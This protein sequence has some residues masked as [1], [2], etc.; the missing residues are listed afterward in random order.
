MTHTPQFVHFA[1]M[2]LALVTCAAGAA[3]PAGDDLPRADSSRLEE[4]IRALG[5]FG[6]NPEGGVSR[7][8]F[9]DADVTGRAYI[10]SLM[11]AA[12]RS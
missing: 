11:Q 9:S 1:G 8:A 6:A 12:G 4:R 10:A 2:A 7:V 3:A 5:R